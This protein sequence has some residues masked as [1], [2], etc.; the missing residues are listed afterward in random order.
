MYRDDP[1]QVLKQGLNGGE[2][3]MLGES[4]GGV[5]VVPSSKFEA[6]L[7]GGRPV[8]VNVVIPPP[9]AQFAPTGTEA[10]LGN[11]QIVLTRTFRHE[12]KT[13]Y[14]MAD[15]RHPDYRFFLTP[16]QLNL[17]IQE[18]GIALDRKS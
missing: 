14:E 15:S 16:A 5:E 1:Q 2:V 11:H 3:I 4:L 7:K 6:T 12:G 10:P 9:R 18:K 17:I 13:W 8:L